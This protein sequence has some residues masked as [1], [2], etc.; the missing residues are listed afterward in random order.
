MRE[1]PMSGVPALTPAARTPIDMTLRETGSASMTSRVRTCVFDACSTST[2]G[3][4]PD[5]VNDSARVPSFISA[6]IETTVS[7]GTSMPVRVSVA[8]PLKENVSV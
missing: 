3:D 5:T 6:F 8:K 1:P 4:W 2:C 7:D